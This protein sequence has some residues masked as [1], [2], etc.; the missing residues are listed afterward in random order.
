MGT[1]LPFQIISFFFGVLELIVLF[2]DL[3]D[4]FPAV[5][6]NLIAVIPSFL[7]SF[8][9]IFKK[10]RI[11]KGYRFLGFLT[12]LFSLSITA[13][14]FLEFLNVP[15]SSRNFISEPV[16]QDFIGKL[17]ITFF[18]VILFIWG[19]CLNEEMLELPNYF[20]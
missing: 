11:H 12:I 20:V 5:L 1:S 4:G 14:W 19:L 15:I 17:I 7:Y 18:N 10:V 13:Y 3:N 6:F 9:S 16:S 2:L 8:A